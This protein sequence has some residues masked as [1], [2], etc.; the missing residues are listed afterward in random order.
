MASAHPAGI[1]QTDQI[2][3]PDAWSFGYRHQ[4][5]MSFRI[6][7]V[8]LMDIPTTAE[9][10]VRF[11]NLVE[12]KPHPSVTACYS[13]GGEGTE[14]DFVPHEVLLPG[15]SGGKTEVSFERKIFA[16]NAANGSGILEFF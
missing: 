2:D 8:V 6:W 1:R 9:R 12:C 10:A 16:V 7:V 13:G 11:G 14:V 3:Q 4:W 15:H 5:E